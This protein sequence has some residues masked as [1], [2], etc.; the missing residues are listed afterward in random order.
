M[1]ETKAHR[2]I[3]S[4]VRR[5][6]HLTPAQERAL[7]KLWTDFGVDHTKSAADFPAIFGR[8]AP[9]IVEI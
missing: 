8:E 6:R 9:V 7:Q 2:P 3:R 1:I 4:F 5:E